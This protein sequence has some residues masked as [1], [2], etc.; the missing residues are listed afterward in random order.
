M[1]YPHDIEERLGF[2]RIRSM[3]EERLHTSAARAMLAESAFDTSYDKVAEKLR[4]ADEMRLVLLSGDGFPLSGYID[5]TPYL[6]RIRV[7]GTHLTTAEM[8]DLRAAFITVGELTGFFRTE[9]RAALYPLLAE[10]ACRVAVSCDVPAMVERVIDRFGTVRDSASVELAQVRARLREAEG[11]VGRRL[12]ALM[13]EAQSAGIVDEDAAISIRDGRA[14]IPVSAANKRKIRGFV[15]DESATGKTAYIEPIEV[16]ELNNEIK[17]LEL[18]ER[19]QVLK[20]L[21]R[22]ADEL[23]PFVDELLDGDMFLSQIDFIKG[24]AEIALSMDAQMPIMTAERQIY[25]KDGRHPLLEQTL[26]REGKSIVPLTMRLDGDKHIL[27]IS[28]PNAGGKSVCLKSV[29]LLQYMM[30]C[31]WL[32]PASPVSEMSVFDDIFVDIGDQQSIDNDL[33]TY[34][35][36]LGNMRVMLRHATDRS[37]VL[38]D[39]FGTGTE[40]ALGGAIAETIL[41]RL[42]ARGVFGVITTHYSNI[43]YYASKARGVINGAMNFDVRNIQPLFSLEMGK[44][45]SS[46]AFEIARKTGLPED[47]VRDAQEKVGDDK[48]NIERQLREIAR[49]KRYWE[50]KR[51]RIRIAQKR[52]DRL[53]EEYEASAAEVLAKRNELIAEAKAEAARIVADAGKLIE[54]TIREIKEAQAEKERTRLIRKEFESARDGFGQDSRDD[55]SARIEAKMQRMKEA[56]ERRRKRREESADTTA[57][58]EVEQ[59]RRTPV[60]GDKVRMTGQ[61]IAGEVMSVD[62]KKATVAFGHLTTTVELSRLELISASEYKRQSKELASVRPAYGVERQGYDVSQKRLDFKRQIDLRGAR[63]DEALSR[64]QEY[65]DE[66]F[67]LGIDQVKILHGK[68]TGALKE[69][70]RRYLRTLPYVRSAADEHVQFGGAGITVVELDT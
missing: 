40:P 54:K 58:E 22:F 33:S 19:R 52:A 35:S 29:G 45:G 62:G 36:H 34:S 10:M 24:K 70:I 30:Q 39:E 65:M 7:E 46:F 66:A 67:M 61:Q 4:L 1:T 50:S 69:E 60:A 6:K 13:A 56:R 12:R 59:V 42:E 43:K 9:E 38:I 27:V 47:V 21:V 57:R 63:V 26:K 20:V 32:V 8:G 44:P 2:D 11:Q 3:T 14:V 17:E 25:I 64:V 23:R 48:V 28:G 16:V 5:T 18:E 41:E 51:D 55:E 37:L 15:H 31:G 49:D 53:V 68:G